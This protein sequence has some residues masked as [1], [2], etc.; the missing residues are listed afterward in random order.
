MEKNRQFRIYNVDGS[1][2]LRK[3]K[4]NVNDI[5]DYRYPLKDSL[6]P[7]LNQSSPI[8]MKNLNALYYQIL[9]LQDLDEK[10]RDCL[11][12]QIIEVDFS[13]V[14]GPRISANNEIKL[15]NI[16]DGQDDKRGII[17]SFHDEDVRF[18]PFDK[19]GSMTRRDRITVVREDIKKELDKRLLLDFPFDRMPIDPSKYF[20]YR[21]LYLSD[22]KRVETVDLLGIENE[23]VALNENTVIVI[24]DYKQRK[25]D[26]DDYNLEGG[27]YTN[28][29][30]TDS[31]GRF[32]FIKKDVDELK[33]EEA[34][35]SG[36]D[37]S[38][39]AIN[40]FDG[41]GLICPE[42][43]RCI[44]EDLKRIGFISENATSFQVRMP[45]VKGM[46]HEVDY[47]AFLKKECEIDKA[48]IKDYFGIERDL[49]Q[50]RIILSKSMFKAADWMKQAL[51]DEQFIEDYRRIFP[52]DKDIDVMKYYFKKFDEYDHALYIRQTD[53]SL[54]GDKVF[55]NYQFIS[56]LD[57][58]KN[59][60]EEVLSQHK[61]YVQNI[62][63]SFI[64]K[65]TDYEDEEEVSDSDTEA[66]RVAL[67]RN[68]AFV[69]DRYIRSMI[70]GRRDSL[71]R[72]TVSGNVIVNGENRF[73][74]GDLWV[75]LIYLA[76]LTGCGNKDKINELEEYSLKDN[77]FY[78]AGIGR[79]VL[80]QNRSFK[81]TPMYA[82]LRNPHLSQNEE[83]VSY[84]TKTKIGLS[85]FTVELV[86]SEYLKDLRG[87]IMI[88]SQSLIPNLLGGADF[89]G[90]IVKVIYDLDIVKAI[91][92]AVYGHKTEI[93]DKGRPVTLSFRKLPVV[94]INGIETESSAS[95]ANTHIT[96]ETIKNTFSNSIG[97][98]SNLAFKFSQIKIND[99]LRKILPD[100]DYK[101]A[102]CTITT[103]IDIDAAKHGVH[104]VA[105]VKQL[106]DDYQAIKKYIGNT[107]AEKYLKIK[108]AFDDSGYETG[109]IKVVSKDGY[110]IISKGK[111]EIARIDQ[112]DDSP[113]VLLL[114]AYQDLVDDG[115]K[116]SQKKAGRLFKFED[117]NWKQSLDQE[118]LD[119]TKVLMDSYG[120][121][122]ERFR[123]R[124]DLIASAKKSM[125]DNRS[126]GLNRF[127]DI[128]GSLDYRVE[129]DITVDDAYDIVCE[130]LI[131][132]VRELATGLFPDQCKETSSLIERIDLIVQSMENIERFYFEFKEYIEDIV[133]VD[134][135]AEVVKDMLFREE[136]ED[137]DVNILKTI[138]YI[139]M[140]SK[141]E[142][143]DYVDEVL[144]R[145]RLRSDRYIDAFD[146][147][148]DAA[149]R[150]G[151]DR[152]TFLSVLN[153]TAQDILL[154]LFDNN[155]REA[156]KHV[157]AVRTTKKNNMGYARFMWEVVPGESLLEET[158]D[159]EDAE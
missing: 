156:L 41:E 55:L 110:F 94:I 65:E 23:P 17:L 21:G 120:F 148:Y 50:T 87:V 152:N 47:H 145:S 67:G 158:E 92:N 31:E 79:N 150:D 104:P 86:R 122:Y 2:L 45:F 119:R 37:K 141:Y 140:S 97:Q 154:E 10:D 82:L 68:H 155:G 14:F 111:K 147:V 99:E 15:R 39:P 96:Y 106:K 101:C 134:D 116:N 62:E 133:I 42:L 138:R 32:D 91:E 64:K 58:R 6:S 18:V 24:D 125:Y 38:L 130:Y 27:I 9:V 78:I 52:K 149:I 117:E 4:G 46:L 105:N 103:G 159:S 73:L 49:S 151:Y 135:K 137:K 29:R 36:K 118:L 127:I 153:D 60:F 112:N 51:K 57:I 34:E 83:V 54:R 75:L 81:E 107:N 26:L 53:I 123:K 84:S 63:N 72:D 98:L 59:S 5:D 74:S 88:S 25:Q 7:I 89:D 13:K 70:E 102:Q 48:Q 129:E 114:Q 142:D 115:R 100:I 76:R 61:E 1:N 80:M 66:W 126:K 139:L 69:N 90:D 12:D 93:N 109:K 77:D 56:T 157:Y 113:S 132:G 19:S 16:F 131:E 95:K 121:Y 35:L 3:F 136:Y 146:E 11:L 144:N 22:G 8:L 43:S 28:S 40:S 85:S 143:A 124:Y 44:N 30:K 33:R 108:D 128:F 71:I 20:A